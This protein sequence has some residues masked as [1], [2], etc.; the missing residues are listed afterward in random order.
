MV[1]VSR[2]RKRPWFRVAEVLLVPPLLVLTKRRW[3]GQHHLPRTGGVIVVANHISKID[4]ITFGHFVH[5]A[6]RVPHYL[7][8]VELFEHKLLGPIFRGTD[9][10]PVY[11][12]GENAGASVRAAVQALQDGHCIVVYAEATITRDPNLW[13][14]VG[15]TGAARIAMASGA[16]V[17]PVAQWGA[18]RILAPYQKRLTLFPRKT[19]HVR[20]G[21]PVQLDDLAG[22]GETPEVLAEATERIM[23]AI[24]AELEV[25]RAERA[26]EE[27]FDPRKAGVAEYGDPRRRRPGERR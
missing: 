25:I 13:P 1:F 24:T 5:G 10:I 17:I 18:H 12:G 3:H 7:A 26:P 27:R 6:G 2:D 15:K 14:M 20:A 9:M 19:V 22:R 11:R 21:K 16:P 4:P 23:T 8:K